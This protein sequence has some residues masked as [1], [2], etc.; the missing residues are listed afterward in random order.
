MVWVFICNYGRHD[1]TLFKWNVLP[2]GQVTAISPHPKEN[3]KL[4][5]FLLCWKN[6]IQFCIP[7][8]G[9]IWHPRSPII[10]NYNSDIVQWFFSLFCWVLHREMDLFSIIIGLHS[11]FIRFCDENW[12]RQQCKIY[13]NFILSSIF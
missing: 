5:A 9:C 11:F 4:Y 7:S 2:L 6:S 10:V 1:S 3:N 8:V 13:L 12:V